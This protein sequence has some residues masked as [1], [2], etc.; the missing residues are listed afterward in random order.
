[1]ILN[2]SDTDIVF[3]SNF[4]TKM[5]ETN[6]NI[7][8]KLPEDISYKILTY[9]KTDMENSFSYEEFLDLNYDDIVKFDIKDLNTEFKDANLFLAVV[10]ERFFT[11]Y[12]YGIES[13]LG[14]K[15]LSFDEINFLIKSFVLFIAPYI[16]KSK[17]VFSGYVDNFMST[18]TYYI[19]EQYNKR[20]LSFHEVS[21]IDN[22]SNF[23]FEGLFGKPVEN[24]ITNETPKS[25]ND[26]ISFM[27]DYDASIDIKERAI[28]NKSMKKGI[29]GIF[30]PNIFDIKYIKFAIFGYKADKKIL[31]Y[32]NID[33]PNIAKKL[34]ANIVRVFN[35]V[36][37]SLFFKT[38]NFKH[39]DDIK[40]I[41]FPLQL[42]P[43][44]S[45]ASRAPFYMNQLSTIEN[46]SKSLP[47]G[48]KLLVKEHPIALGMNNI[49][50]YKKIQDIPNV[51]FVDIYTKGTDL[52]DI[53]DLMITFGGTTLFESILRGKKVL[54]LLEDYT[55]INSR[56]IFNVS[57]RTDIRKFIR[58]ALDANFSDEEKLFEKEKML[59]FFYQRGFP[60]FEDFEK[61][62]AKNII[63]VYKSLKN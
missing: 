24:L 14:N 9:R 5:N 28:K 10:C 42:Q 61:N 6:R 52:I 16:K 11:N 37:A 1:L 57:G 30:S 31:I 62:I 44:A 60:R 34:K 2:S 7:A 40:Y 19:A 43:E 33:K 26:L 46:I 45:T 23:L 53:S 17:L 13:T 54:M 50:F 59:N 3:V 8:S 56:M 48:Y 29:F 12:Y 58:K 49:S 25:Y 15:N 38:F 51:D 39:R 41:Y 21:I 18:I 20:C 47:L 32:M 35:K 36:V 55:Y 63:K 4:S 27:N 22:N